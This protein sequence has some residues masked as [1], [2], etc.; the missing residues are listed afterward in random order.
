MWFSISQNTTDY[1]HWSANTS[2]RTDL[3]DD[4]LANNFSSVGRT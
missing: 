2:T 1:S 4:A 3:D